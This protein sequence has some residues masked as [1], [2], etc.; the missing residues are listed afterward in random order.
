MHTR[1]SGKYFTFINVSTALT[2][3]LKQVLEYIEENLADFAYAEDIYFK[4]K[5]IITELLTNGFKHA[6]A[7]T[8]NISIDIDPQYITIVKTDYGIP[9]PLVVSGS[10]QGTKTMLSYDIMH[11]LYAINLNARQVKFLVEDIIGD[12]TDIKGVGEHFGL[13]IITKC[14]EEF[15]YDFDEASKLNTFTAKVKLPPPAH[16]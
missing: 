15:I 9:F 16:V 8:V 6:G 13:L 12:E 11:H 10:P 7:E 14:S 5:A 2:S 1:Y 4:T 3:S